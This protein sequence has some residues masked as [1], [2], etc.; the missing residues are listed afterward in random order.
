MAVIVVASKPISAKRLE[1]TSRIAAR[2]RSDRS[3]CGGRRTARSGAAF[4]AFDETEGILV[5]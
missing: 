1:A 5:F 3:C 2:V 4:F